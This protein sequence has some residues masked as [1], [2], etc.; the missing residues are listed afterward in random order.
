MKLEEEPKEEI[1]EEPKTN[2]ESKDIYL[3]EKLIFISS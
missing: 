2:E 1:K 3:Q